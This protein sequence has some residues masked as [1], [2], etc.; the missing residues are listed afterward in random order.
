M[1]ETFEVLAMIMRD[2]QDMTGVHVQKQAAVLGRLAQEIEH[3]DRAA[4]PIQVDHRRRFAG[5]RKDLGRIAI[6][7]KS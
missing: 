1:Q 6:N 4:Q 2:P 3:M 5:A 7:T